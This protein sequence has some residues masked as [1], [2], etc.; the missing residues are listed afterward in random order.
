MASSSPAPIVIPPSQDF[1]G[2]DGPWSSFYLEIGSPAQDVKVLISTAGYQTWAVVPQGCIASD[3]PDCAT[4]RGGHFIPSQSSTWNYNNESVNGTFT[5]GLET[6]L[7]YSGNGDYGYDTIVLGYQGSNGPSLQQQTIAG[8]AT[9]EFYLGIF[10][11]NPR[12]TNFSTLDDPIPSYMANMK[13]RSMIPSLSWG[14]TAG[15]QYRLGTV[16]G[17]LTLGGF[18]SSRFVANDVTFAFNQVDERDLTVDIESIVMTTSNNSVHLLNNS[19]AAYVDSTIPYFYLP[20]EVCQHFEH[21]FGILWDNDVQAYLVNDSL[22]KSLHAQ[23]ATVTF[24]IGNTTQSVKISLPYAAFDLIAEYPLVTNTTRYFPLMPATNES[25]Y[26]LGRAFLQEAYVF[27]W[28]PRPDK[29]IWL[30]FPRYLTADYERRNFSISQC[31]W[32]LGAR[33]NIV[34]IES[35]PSSEANGKPISGTSTTASTSGRIAGIVIGSSVGLLFVIFLAFVGK[36]KFGTNL[37]AEF[38]ELAAKDAPFPNEVET[39]NAKTPELDGGSVLKPEIDG[40]RN[41]GAELEAGRYIQE[42]KSNEGIGPELAIS[43]LQ[44]SELPS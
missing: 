43:N 40:Y 35:P 38:H 25:Q 7:G 17:S 12:S 15:N 16:L 21:A 1:D 20:L 18:D 37:G 4:S 36:R 42:M 14:Y 11:L 6:N 26:T 9:K 34:A 24:S 3:P 22:H 19:I 27:L 41:P 23:N 44:I 39:P 2:N 8:I 29:F 31:S 33:E 10:G 5:L 13:N 28:F 32:D 30:T